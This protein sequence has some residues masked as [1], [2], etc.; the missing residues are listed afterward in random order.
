MLRILAWFQRK[1]IYVIWWLILSF[2]HDSL[3]GIEQ[4]IIS[5]LAWI[6]IQVKR[7]Y[8]TWQ[9]NQLFKV[10]ENSIKQCFATNIVQCCEK[11]W[12][13]FR[14][15]IVYNNIVDSYIIGGPIQCVVSYRDQ[16]A[17]KHTSWLYEQCAQQNIV[18][19]V[20]LRHKDRVSV[21]S[22]MWCLKRRLWQGVDFLKI[23]LKFT[24]YWSN[25]FSLSF[26]L[27]SSTFMF[28]KRVFK[29]DNSRFIIYISSCSW[30]RLTWS[31]KKLRNYYK[32]FHW[33]PTQLGI[34]R[35]ITSSKT[36]FLVCFFFNRQFP[37]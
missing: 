17:R 2:F 36:I 32:C 33:L 4:V 14:A 13:A 28:S 12:T 35:Q 24:L 22:A 29:T 37:C 3:K 18:Q 9:K 10:D 11:Y 31:W 21:S 16:C 7:W 19:S 26:E 15:W 30:A 5:T 6:H 1:W 23:Y 27:S 25:S 20:K 34:P 8:F